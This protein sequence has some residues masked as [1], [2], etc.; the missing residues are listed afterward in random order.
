MESGPE[1]PGGIFGGGVFIRRPIQ[2]LNGGDLGFLDEALCYLKCCE[3]AV[4][5]SGVSRAGFTFQSA[6]FLGERGHL[7]ILFPVQH[8]SLLPSHA[9][10]LQA[11]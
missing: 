3:Y 6:E 5:V 10:P 8:G 11:L 9:N 1:S 7:Y 4:V 2:S